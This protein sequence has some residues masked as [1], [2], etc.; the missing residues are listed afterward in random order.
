MK[1]RLAFLSMLLAFIFAR[2]AAAQF[3]VVYNF[4][5]VP[6]SLPYPGCADGNGPNGGVIIDPAGNLFGTTENGGANYEG[7]VFKLDASGNETVLYNFCS[8]A[9]CADGATPLV[10]LVR[11]ASGNLYGT[12]TGGGANFA[13]T[14]FK[15]DT[16][17]NETVLHS[18]CSGTCADGSDPDAGLLR[19]ADGNLYGTTESNGGENGGTL[20]KIDS[21]GN[22]SV[23]YSFCS[24]SNCV[25]GGS[26]RAAP[27]RDAAGNLYGTTLVGGANGDGTVFKLDSAGNF[28]VLYNFC[29]LANCADGTNPNAAVI[30]DAGGNLYGTTYYGGANN[31][32]TVFKLDPEG[33]FSVLHTFG[34]LPNDADGAY[35]PYALLQ[36]TVG[37]LYGSASGGGTNGAG[38]VFK[39]D[40]AGN[41]TVLHTFGSLPNDPDGTYVDAAL[42]LD[43]AGNLYGTAGG[44]GTNNGGTVFKIAGV[45]RTTPTVIWPNPSAISYGTSLSGTELD[46]QAVIPGTTT[47]IAGTYAYTPDAGT[48]LN[49][50][51]QTLSVT[52]TPANG[53][54]YSAATTTVPLNVSK[55]LLTVHPTPAQPGSSLFS[56]GYGDNAP[57]LSDLYILT[58]FVN[59]DGP[60]VVSGAPTVS[61]DWPAQPNVGTY[62]MTIGVGTLTATNYNFTAITSGSV[63]VV[64]A[65]ISINPQFKTMKYGAAI[66]AFSY[67]GT[68]L[69][70]GQTLASLLNVAPTLAANAPAQPGVGS[71]PINL[72][73][74]GLSAGPNYTLVAGPSATLTV[75]PAT[76]TAR[77]DNTSV[78]SGDYFPPFAYSLGGFVNGDTAAVVSGTAT[79]TS[80]GN[81]R[82]A[83]GTYPITFSTEGLTAANY[84]ILYDPATLTIRP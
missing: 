74:A 76:L 72:S 41:F 25:D 15:L 21:S 79:L 28:L 56:V 63:A 81:A 22:F 32:G 5:S 30:Q 59:G 8:L 83:P 24:L 11:D 12:T 51:P 17:G 71:Y 66:P 45:S 23:L 67:V 36:D 69:K 61:I 27:I 70:Y 53:G 54:L 14:V 10:A 62:P 58:G 33:N 2:P 40:L 26:P 60:S 7:T 6:V 34:S 16:S 29:S 80:T 73:V 31:Q 68:G 46:A 77:A 3:S 4:C 35:S 13:G 18:F 1:I 37:N 55:A 48:V 19:D 47:S 75:N 78:I 64:P 57:Y 52:F 9:N 43:V 44:G 50:G 42:I 82:S 38:T 49:A 20:F 65:V 39:I 84:T